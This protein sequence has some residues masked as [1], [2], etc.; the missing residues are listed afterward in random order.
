M[1][2]E[3]VPQ[4]ASPE[5]ILRDFAINRHRIGDVNPEFILYELFIRAIRI[6]LYPRPLA[7]GVRG[8]DNAIRKDFAENIP[9]GVL[10]IFRAQYSRQGSRSLF[11]FQH[12]RPSVV[13]DD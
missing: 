8:I 6:L 5:T 12:K 9:K 2:P 10:L 13:V 11:G 3:H 4:E 7:R 1:T